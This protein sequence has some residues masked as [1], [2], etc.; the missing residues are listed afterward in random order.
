MFAK[1]NGYLIPDAY[2][3]KPY[4][5]IFEFDELQHFTAFRR[6]TLVVYPEDF[7]VVFELQK[8]LQFCVKYQ[9]AAIRRGPDR[10][11]RKIADFP[12]VNGRAAQRAL[13]DTFRDW[14][15]PLHGLHPT[16]R[17]A[18][19][20]VVDI[21]IGKLTGE[22]AKDRIRSFLKHRLAPFEWFP[23]RLVWR[24]VHT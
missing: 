2:F 10:F 20:E 17:L 15:P 3:P 7:P 16:M 13:F 6:Q 23:R 4:H 9:E 8:Y 21:L 14:L 11:R 12:F 24:K 5:F 19:F 18:E 22:A 1:A